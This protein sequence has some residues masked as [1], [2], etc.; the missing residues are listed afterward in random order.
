MMDD[1]EGRLREGVL[2]LAQLAAS[3]T[4]ENMFD[5]ERPIEERIFAVEMA[6]TALTEEQARIT[7]L[8]G[9][10]ALKLTDALGISE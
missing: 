10:L 4:G 1:V 5:T 2:E 6:L 3:M 9:T 8:I 7:S